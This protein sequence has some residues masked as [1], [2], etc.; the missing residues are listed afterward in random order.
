MTDYCTL[1]DGYGHTKLI[2]ILDGLTG[3]ERLAIQGFG[4]GER[5]IHQSTHDVD[6]VRRARDFFDAWLTKME[7]QG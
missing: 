5:F 7:A 4:M 3:H 6:D 2:P 1:P